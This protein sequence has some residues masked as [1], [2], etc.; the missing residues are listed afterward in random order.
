MEIAGLS[1]VLRPSLPP[2]FYCLQYGN[3]TCV[4]PGDLVTYEPS[5]GHTRGEVP[6]KAYLS[7]LLCPS[8]GWK[9][10]HL[11]ETLPLVV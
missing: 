11:Q 6:D 5:G 7:F 9:L 1:L 3:M 4:G 10:E 8:K 2:V